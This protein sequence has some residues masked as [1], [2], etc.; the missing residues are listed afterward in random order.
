[1]TAVWITIGALFVATAG[2]RAVGPSRSAAGA[3]PV[4]RPP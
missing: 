1:M 3:C 2:M 4:E